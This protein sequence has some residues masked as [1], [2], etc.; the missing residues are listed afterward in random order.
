MSQLKSVDAQS[1]VRTQTQPVKKNQ[2]PA[3]SVK[4]SNECS[5]SIDMAVTVRQIDQRRNRSSLTPVDQTWKSYVDRLFEQGLLADEIQRLLR[6]AAETSPERDH[7]NLQEV[8]NYIKTK[9]KPER[10]KT[11]PSGIE[12]ISRSSKTMSPFRELSRSGSLFQ[13]SPSKEMKREENV[14]AT[15]PSLSTLVKDYCRSL[16]TI[17]S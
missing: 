11:A 4:K 2:E 7:H 9:A 6:E 5:G 10:A 1:H 16:A 13:S 15:Q 3:S 14:M 17:S 8:F 12:F